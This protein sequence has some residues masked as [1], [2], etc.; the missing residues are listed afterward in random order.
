MLR[1]STF[2][3]HI[4][5]GRYASDHT[6]DLPYPDAARQEVSRMCVDMMRDIMVELKTNPEWRMEVTDEIG[7][8]L[9]LFSVHYRGF[10]ITDGLSVSLGRGRSF[11]L[12]F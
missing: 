6:V 8:P 1:M 7:E 11:A 5:L 12:Y 4:R 3:F 9:Y 10:Q 2:V